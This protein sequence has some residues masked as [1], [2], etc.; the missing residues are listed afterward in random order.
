MPTIDVYVE[1]E[2]GDLSYME[3]LLPTV[4]TLES[5]S[6][7]YRDIGTYFLVADSTTNE[8]DTLVF[9]T[10]TGTK[11]SLIKTETLFQTNAALSG[12]ND[13]IDQFTIAP[14]QSGIKST[15]TKFQI[16]EVI[17]GFLKT[18]VDVKIRPEVVD[19]SRIKTIIYVNNLVNNYEDIKDIVRFNSLIGELITEDEF[20]IRKERIKNN[21]TIVDIT[22]PFIITASIDGD[23]FST[24]RKINYINSD[25]TVASGSIVAL[26]SDIFNTIL[27]TRYVDSDIF[28]TQ[29]KVIYINAEMEVPL[30]N[31]VGF[32]IDFTAAGWKTSNNIE[33][34]I[35]TWS[36]YTADFFLD[37]EEFVDATTTAWVDLIDY[38]SEIDE[39]NSYFLVDGERVV[40][41]F[42][43][44]NNGKRMFYNPPDDFLSD[45]VL[46]Y[47][48]HMQNTLGDVKEEDYHL[49]YGYNVTYNKVV[50]W[51][52]N[53]E[54]EILVTA[55]NK[56]TCPNTVT[57]FYRFRTKDYSAYDIPSSILPVEDVDLGAELR[58]QSTAFYY[59]RTYTVTVSGVKDLAGNEMDPYT[60]NFT[61]EDPTI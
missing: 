25:I 23:I 3:S 2:I 40:V 47:T 31:C 19:Y 41:T 58:T 4:F 57:E 36:L 39:G 49:L 42:S 50:D 54:V 61:I 14:T 29:Q 12:S 59:G 20:R 55:K 21:D 6:S 27:K 45:D 37:V 5:G 46:I 28:N 13:I 7:A 56:A 16:N 30:S 35:R 15:V 10:V 53:K 44:I 32:Y 48:V 52:V 9:F 22:F 18:A 24:A 43:G 34:D 26:P 8:V 51:G 11:T 38:V 17:D 1:S 60:W 33:C